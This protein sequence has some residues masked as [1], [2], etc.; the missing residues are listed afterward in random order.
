MTTSVQNKTGK[1]H[2]LTLF[3]LTPLE[4]AEQIISSQRLKKGNGLYGEGIYFAN[5]YEANTIFY[6]H[7]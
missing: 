7:S 2:R 6:F 4:C 1:I 5:T 3:Y